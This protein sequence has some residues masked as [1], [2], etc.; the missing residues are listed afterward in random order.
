M[1]VGSAEA[2]PSRGRISNVSPMGGA[3]MERAVGDRVVVD[4]PGGQLHFEIVDINDGGG[5][6][7]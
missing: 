5:Q 2:D 6:A 1:I 7:E 4:T 3:L